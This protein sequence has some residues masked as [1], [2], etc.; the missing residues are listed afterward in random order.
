MVVVRDRR[1]DDLEGCVAALRLTH[2]ADGYPLNWPADPRAWLT[3]PR[4]LRAWVAASGGVIAG[5]V[6]LQA[7]GESEAELSRL[8]VD[9]AARRLSVATELLRRAVE[10]AAEQR[11]RPTL[12][13]VDE[14]RSAAVAFYE[15]AGWR[16]THTSEAGWAG[17]R[18]ERVVLRHYA[19]PEPWAGPGG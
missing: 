6:A 3:P 18:G 11:L 16:F 10:W 8:F 14:G 9:P 4:L 1:D 2:A 17:P 5:H 7:V 19:A 15:A 12:N 13:L